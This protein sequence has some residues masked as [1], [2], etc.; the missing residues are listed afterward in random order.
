MRLGYHGN[1]LRA[2]DELGGKEQGWRNLFTPNVAE[3]LALRYD[4]AAT[5][6]VFPDSTRWWDPSQ[7]PSGHLPH[8]TNGIPCR[9]MRE[10]SRPLPRYRNPNWS[11]P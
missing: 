8:S 11:R 7:P 5:S 9:R 10:S 3:L 1:E 6:G 4:P 2:Y